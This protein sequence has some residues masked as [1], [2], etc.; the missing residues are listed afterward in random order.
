MYNNS[1]HHFP[2][3]SPPIPPPMEASRTMGFF[4]PTDYSSLPPLSMGVSISSSSSS[5]LL[6]PYLSIY[7]RTPRQMYTESSLNSTFLKGSVKS[8]SLSD[9]GTFEVLLE[10]L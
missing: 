9:D 7:P 1:Q 3:I 10:K 4:N 5:H 6:L 8:Y 2:Y